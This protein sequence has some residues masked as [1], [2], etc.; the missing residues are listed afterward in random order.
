[1]RLTKSCNQCQYW[2]CK[3][4]TNEYECWKVDHNCRINHKGSSCLMESAGIPKIV[5][6]SIITR[7]LRY[8]FYLGDGSSKAFLEVVK[9]NLYPGLTIKKQDCVGHVQMRMGTR[10]RAVRV[11]LKR[12]ILTDGKAI[13]WRN[14]LT[15]QVINTLQ[16][17][18]G[19]A[20][21]YS[22]KKAIAANHSSLFRK[23]F[24]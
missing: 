14:R 12:K 8:L 24:T 22:M 10:L 18:Y 16:N 13:S 5:Q 17:H 1:M 2:K 23:R 4:E 21:L 20:N 15:E 7:K 11:S 6:R 19:C 3:K 9:N